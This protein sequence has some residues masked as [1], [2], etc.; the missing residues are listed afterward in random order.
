[1]MPGLSGATMA[2]GDSGAGVALPAAEGT[3][4]SRPI[5][6]GPDAVG[7]VRAIVANIEGDWQ[8]EGGRDSISEVNGLLVVRA[9][10][11]TH[12]RLQ[13]LLRKLAAARQPAL[14][15]APTYP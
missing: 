8:V 12:R 6:A 4:R 5:Y 13:E 15:S 3:T 1:M 2:G 11:R 10:T 14:E 9:D 7:L